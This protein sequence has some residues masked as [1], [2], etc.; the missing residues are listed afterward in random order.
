[1]NRFVLLFFVSILIS[2]CID[3]IDITIPKSTTS[4]L[5]VEGVITDEPGPYTVKLSLASPAD[6]FLKFTKPV[7]ATQVTL[8]DNAGNA[9]V[10]NE[11]ETGTFQTKPNGM[12][13]V[14]GREYFIRVETRDGKTYESLPDRMNPVGSVDS[15]YYEFE[16]F[17][18][19]NEQTRYGFRFSNS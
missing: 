16:S 19:L 8:F 2:S 17:E 10:M 3:R 1:M 14:I 4:Q 11:I 5:V 6:G 18:P 12:R 15:L 9:E 13:G 7:T